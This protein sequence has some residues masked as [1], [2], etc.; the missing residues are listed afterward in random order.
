MCAQISRKGKL[1]SDGFDERDGAAERRASSSTKYSRS[2]G[3]S[4]YRKRRRRDRAFTAVVV[5][6]VLAIIA[7]GVA[8]FGRQLMTFEPPSLSLPS[9][10]APA[11]TSDE[12]KKEVVLVEPAQISLAFAGDVIMNSAVV[13]SGSDYSGNYNYSHLF[14]HLT[15][16]ISGY[17]VRALSQETAMAGSSYGYGNY[18]PLNAPNELGT[19]EVNAGFN[20]ILHATD[21]AVD[22]GSEGLHDELLWWQSNNPT[23]P[24]LGVAEPDLAGN[25]SLSDYVNNVYIFEKAGFKV[26]ILNHSTD[27]A[28]D[29]RGMVS[30]LDEEKI[31]SDV[32]KARELGAEMIVA[33]PHWG[34]EGD[35]EVSEEET[36]F[37]Q[38]YANHGVDVIVGTHPRVLQR[39]EILTGPEGHQTV[40]FYSLG[41][42]IE[43]IGTNNLLGGIAELTLARDAQRTYHVTGAKLKPI[44]TNRASGT[45]F[46]SYLLA[47]YTDDVSGSSWDGQSRDSLNERCSEILGTGYNAGTYEL[48]L[49]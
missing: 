39:A 44:V 30:S 3:L 11:D 48:S 32:A 22:T 5:I 46:T 1:V 41:C 16:E 6:I 33:C 7:G 40:C 2:Q 14:T 27:I 29:N 4:T 47:D 25:P 18:Y 35:P 34:N 10:N 45:D 21:H 23:I 20:V 19:A 9:T 26:A 8:L 43:S 38:V 28:E 12:A 13:D 36:R 42:L 24:V 37:A 31:A 17:D 49:V 15:P